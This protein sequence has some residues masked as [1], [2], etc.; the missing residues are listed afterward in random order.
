VIT[1]EA[2]V[3]APPIAP[4]PARRN[5]V[6][7][8]GCFN[9]LA[10]VTQ[11][12]FALWARILRAVPDSRLIMKD[13]AMDDEAA[14]ARVLDSFGRHG[15][16][17]DRIVLRGRT[18]HREHLNA[19]AEVDIALDPFPQ[20]GG[21]STYDAL[22]MGVP[23]VAMLG[24][25]GPGRVAAAILHAVGLQDWVASDAEEYLRLAV[26]RSGDLESLAKLRQAM[27]A[28]IMASPA[29][30]PQRYTEAVEEAYR[31]MWR[32]WCAVAR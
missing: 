32:R 30:D 26:T 12:V 6:V 19:F 14:R 8:F 29:G 1:A 31:A 4:L 9:R 2:P 22:W 21:I 3:D 23:V 11:P 24:T 16:G 5:G 7:T 28:R 17:A 25:S 13:G 10:K 27:R 18:P 15:I 20:N